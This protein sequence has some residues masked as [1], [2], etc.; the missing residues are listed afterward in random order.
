MG[1]NSGFKELT[2]STLIDICCEHVSEAVKAVISNNVI[3]Q[4]AKNLF[5]DN[6][7][8]LL[9]RNSKEIIKSFICPTNAHLNCI[10]TLKFTLKITIN[11]PTYFGLTKPPSGNL[12]SVL[13]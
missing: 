6:S 4:R 7:S 12:R 13:R 8:I 11:A 1:F 9:K 5:C 10:K 3:R 2:A